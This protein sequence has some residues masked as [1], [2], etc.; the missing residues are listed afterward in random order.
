MSFLGTVS[1]WNGER[2]F[3]FI[4][5]EAGGQDL[6]V[7]IK[8]F[9][10]QTFRP[11]VGQRVSFEVESGKDGK[12]RATR[13]LPAKFAAPYKVQQQN[14][15]AKFAARYKPH[16]QNVKPKFDAFGLSMIG[17]FAVLF[18]SAW[19]YW[20]VPIWV[21]GIYLVARRNL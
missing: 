21:G 18:A 9:E 3:G 14:D 20:G 4:R 17:L 5:P 8:A 15:T 16:R 19:R 12:K 13:V 2:A 11:A 1:E 10:G 6:F 7:H